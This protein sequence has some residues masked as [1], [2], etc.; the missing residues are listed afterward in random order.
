MS[1]EPI[2]EYYDKEL[3][4]CLDLVS[5]KKFEPNLIK[6]LTMKPNE[7]LNVHRHILPDEKVLSEKIEAMWFPIPEVTDY[8][9]IFILFVN[10]ESLETVNAIY[11]QYHE[12]MNEVKDI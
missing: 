7:W 2:N 5:F 3:D 9:V 10:K 4:L 6:L 12:L 11:Y 8:S 1:K